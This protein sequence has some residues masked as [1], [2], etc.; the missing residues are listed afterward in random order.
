VLNKFIQDALIICHQGDYDAFRQS[1][2]TTYEPP[3]EV[4]FIRVWSNVA[5]IA[6]ERVLADPREEFN[7]YYVLAKVR[8]RVADKK[9]RRQR[10]IPIMVYQE[11]GQWRLGPAPGEIIDRMRAAMSQPA[12]APVSTRPAQ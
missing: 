4:D 9:N 2:G 7:R 1:F 8:L 12:S 11:G 5:E 3:S 10:D 6:V